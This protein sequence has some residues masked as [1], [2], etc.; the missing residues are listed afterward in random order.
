MSKSKRQN[1]KISFVG[2]NAE[3]VTGSMN[4]VTVEDEQFLIDCG[5]TQSHSIK[6]DFIKN[7]KLPK[8]VKPNK[9]NGVFI[10]HLHVDHIGAISLLVSKG[11]DG[12]IFMPIN[13]IEIA[14][15]ML[16]DCY[17]IM[18]RNAEMLKKEEHYT[19]KDV[20]KTFSQLQ[21]LDFNLEY[22]ITEKVGVELFH[23]G[24]IINSSQVLL[25]VKK[26]CGT[27]KKI[28]FT[29]D[30]GNELQGNPMWCEPIQKVDKA[31]IVVGE[32]TYNKTERTK[33]SHTREK[34]IEKIKVV[35]RDTVAMGGNV[36][37]P[38]FSLSRTQTIL[39]VLYDIYGQDEDFPY[40]VVIDSPLSVNLT[41]LY[42]PILSM[43]KRERMEKIMSW[44]NLILSKDHKAHERLLN[45]NR[46]K[47]IISSSGMLDFGR[48]NSWLK[49]IIGGKSHSILFIGY[50][51]PTSIA[52]RIKGGKA[53]TIKIGKEE[54]KNKCSIT[55]LNSFSSHAQYEE[56]MS[57]YSNIISDEIY[58]VH[59]EKEGR[60]EFCNKL[61]EEI[62]KKNRT[63]KVKATQKESVAF[64]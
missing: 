20:Y 51:S 46:P 27:I 53:K 64:F 18:S 8:E 9:L 25:S 1:Y 40:K 37:L 26:N 15:K 24:H 34:D 6:D 2:N 52:G 23:A 57:Y 32:C 19:M 61:G 22:Q 36:L 56:L 54:F 4:L 7:S 17:Y 59:G 43:D 49:K 12:H 30:I 10:T 11:Y 45:D 14:K 21:E 5:L 33:K 47:L 31:N 62:S 35:V 58:L 60:S 38:S 63:T 13:S 42:L 3:E 41:Q 48:S 55:C 44:D 28:L 39:G 29:G 50:A 16:I